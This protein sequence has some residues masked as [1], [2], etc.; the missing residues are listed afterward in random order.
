MRE[1]SECYQ[2]GRLVSGLRARGDSLYPA[3][4]ILC[5]QYSE[6]RLSREEKPKPQKIPSPP[7]GL[8]SRLFLR[9]PPEEREFFSMQFNAQY[10]T[11]YCPIRKQFAGLFAVPG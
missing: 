7:R 8:G 2:E 9:M 6:V 1:L 5:S 4:V 11:R 3:R 10:L